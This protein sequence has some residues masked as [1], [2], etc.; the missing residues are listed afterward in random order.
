MFEDFWAEFEA[1][2][3]ASGLVSAIPASVK[4]ILT[5]SGYNSA[6]SFKSV[7]ENNL[8]ELESYVE[9]RHRKVVDEFAEYEDIRPFEFLPGHRSLIMAI[10]AEIL[11][12]QSRKKPKVAHSKKLPRAEDENTLQLSLINQLSTY[13]NGI[14]VALDWS[15]SIQEIKLTNTEHSTMAQCKIACPSCKK[16]STLRFEKIWKVTNM[17]RHL[18]T[19]RESL[20]E[21]SAAVE[22]TSSTNQTQTMREKIQ[23]LSVE[24]IDHGENDAN[25]ADEYYSDN[26]GYNIIEYDDEY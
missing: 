11:E 6:L 22:S 14:G 26:L 16:I 4:Q 1:E 8:A 25:N 12:I 19:H 13:A 2:C 24:V 9:A 10:K 17:Y 23:V 7:E 21:T 20:G 5:V 15:S 18:R 3:A